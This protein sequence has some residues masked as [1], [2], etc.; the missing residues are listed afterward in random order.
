M[1][2]TQDQLEER[3]DM[4]KREI[5]QFRYYEMKNDEVV[6]PLIGN[7]WIREYGK[8]VNYLHFHNY[9]EVGICYA[10]KGEVVLEQKV[11]PFQAGSIM[12]VPPY[13]LHTTNSIKGT[14]AYWEW[15]YFD[16]ET[17]LE[18]QYDT[19]IMKLKQ[20]KEKIYEK[21]YYMFSQ[22]NEKLKRILE[23]IRL[24]CLEKVE[25]YQEALKG[26]IQT[27]LVEIIRRNMQ[28]KEK[29]EKNVFITPAIQYVE[30]HFFESISIPKLAEVCNMSESY[31]RKLFVSSMHM[32]PIDFINFVRVQKACH[33]MKST[34]K[35]MEEIS[36]RV[37]FGNI[38]TFN[39]NFKKIFG[40]S[41][42]QW[43]K[44]YENRVGN[45]SHYR[46]SA[47]KGW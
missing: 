14:K 13:F 28:E 36:Y 19:N 38:S 43:K 25:F 20:M 23:L 22:K 2:E 31:F 34:E 37:G 17:I 5:A 33:L 9:L 46:I 44:S 41:P 7:E 1:F 30:E 40:V 21:P 26:L 39:R 18:E 29:Y 11:Y 15:F 4:K 32:K 16:V 45:L 6:L 27:L 42:Y 24:E 47:H 12:I 8:D 35:S 10:G 3:N